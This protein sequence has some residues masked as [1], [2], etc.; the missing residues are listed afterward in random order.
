MSLS[1]GEKIVSKKETEVLILIDLQSARNEVF[2]KKIPK[3]I[4]GS[5]LEDCKLYTFGKSR[6]PMIVGSF[7][8][9]HEDGTQAR[10]IY[11]P[12]WKVVE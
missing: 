3:G 4:K 1:A 8:L 11:G 6:N 5:V 10:V 9:D 7:L 12:D 2:Y